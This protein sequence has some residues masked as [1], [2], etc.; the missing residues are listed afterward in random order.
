M[1]KTFLGLLVLATL[2]SHAAELDLR[3]GES[4]RIN[5]LDC[6]TH[7]TQGVIFNG[8]LSVKAI[9]APIL[10]QAEHSS[11]DVYK[12]YRY[13]GEECSWQGCSSKAM[14]VGTFKVDSGIL[15]LHSIKSITKEMS[16]FMS[17]S[18]KC[19]SLRFFVSGTYK[20]GQ[21]FHV[22]NR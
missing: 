8:K 18:N 4:V 11:G 16:Q 15:S 19:G 13:S 14:V 22:I 10:C 2:S 9:C 21:G 6:D 5:V 1:N 12:V 3:S 20:G 17:A 7:Q